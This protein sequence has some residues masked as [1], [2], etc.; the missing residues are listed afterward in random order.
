MKEWEA[1]GRESKDWVRWPA[2]NVAQSW[3]IVDKFPEWL[4]SRNAPVRRKITATYRIINQREG[5]VGNTQSVRIPSDIINFC[6]SHRIATIVHKG[7]IY[8][9]EI[10][11]KGDNQRNKGGH[12][13]E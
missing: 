3:A 13:A 2:S 12:L 1:I 11:G 4:E 5:R 7:S 10:N 6:S 9:A 8:E